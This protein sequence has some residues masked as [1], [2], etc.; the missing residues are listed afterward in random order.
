MK[1]LLLLSLL[2]T[3]FNSFS[4]S[5]FTIAGGTTII[6]VVTKDSI[7]IAADSKQSHAVGMIKRKSTTD[8]KIKVKNNIFY[9]MS[10]DFVTI[11]TPEKKEVFNGYLLVDSLLRVNKNIDWVFDKFNLLATTRLDNIFKMMPKKMT[12]PY[13]S[14]IN[15]ILFQF[16][17]ATFNGVT[18]VCRSSEFGFK[19]NNGVIKLSYQDKQNYK[20]PFAVYL[21]QCEE[22]KNKTRSKSFQGYDLSNLKKD[23]ID[24]IRLEIRANP[25]KV[26]EP[27]KIVSIYPKGY[28]WLN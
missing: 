22:I 10:S 19:I 1:P 3:F 20:P 4:Q 15:E 23:L 18:P 21:G 27:I 6:Y 17:I 14:R 24:M 11:S 12:K 9:A 5:N 28:K 26:G 25:D 13:Y 7:V 2:P 16:V 8:T